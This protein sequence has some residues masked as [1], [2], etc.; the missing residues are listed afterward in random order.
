M[1]PFVPPRSPSSVVSPHALDFAPRHGTPDSQRNETTSRADLRC[2]RSACRCHRRFFLPV[3][4]IHPMTY[5][6]ERP[7]G[8]ALF[9]SAPRCALKAFSLHQNLPVRL[10][11]AKKLSLSNLRSCLP[12]R[13]FQSRAAPCAWQS[14]LPPALLLCT[15]RTSERPRPGLTKSRRLEAR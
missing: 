4:R 11:L 15:Y 10:H 9:C 14:L 12:D 8:P 3:L 1:P 7:A 13:R 6:H 5:M 2:E